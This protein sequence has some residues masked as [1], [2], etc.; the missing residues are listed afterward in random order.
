MHGGGNLRLSF[1]ATRNANSGFVF[2]GWD[3]IFFAV[4]PTIWEGGC[5]TETFAPYSVWTPPAKQ[6]HNLAGS[7]VVTD[8]ADAALEAGCGGACR[9]DLDCA[10]V[11]VGRRPARTFGPATVYLSSPNNQM[12]ADHCAGM[13]VLLAFPHYD[14]WLDSYVPSFGPILL[15]S[16]AYSELTGKA[17]VDLDAYAEWAARFP[18]AD[19]AAALDDI[20]GD[21]QRGMENW[22]RY[23]WM[24]PTLHDS[25]PWEA[26]DVILSYKPKWIGLGMVPPRTNERWLREAL[27]RIPGDIHIHGWALRAYSHHGRLDSMDST[28]WMLDA[29]KVKNA[30]PWL[31]PAECTEIIVKRYQREGRKPTPRI[32]STQGD[33]FS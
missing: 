10:P 5:M 17:K 11:A 1:S 22:R 30:H 20:R 13:P 24:F 15:D 19:A 4:F 9:G 14:A 32:N 6:D 8:F 29:F 21:W 12:S 16:G 27:E 18:F 31:T 33:L 25:D 2:R 3:G 28:N 23:P 7:S 26:L